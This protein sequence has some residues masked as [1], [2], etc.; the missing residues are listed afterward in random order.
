MSLEI[1]LILGLGAAFVAIIILV[2]RFGTEGHTK[3]KRGDGGFFGFSGDG[4]TGGDPG[5]GGG[6][7]G[8]GGGTG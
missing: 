1:L 4:G 2:E 7:D 3:A 5:G 8:G 6:G